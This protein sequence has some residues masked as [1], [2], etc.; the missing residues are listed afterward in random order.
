MPSYVPDKS[1]TASMISSGASVDASD[2]SEKDFVPIDNCL[3]TVDAD[4]FGD[5]PN[6]V[7]LLFS[8]P[9]NY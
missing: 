5:T 6:G 9:G 3:E 2:L 8:S 1:M 7:A 4:T